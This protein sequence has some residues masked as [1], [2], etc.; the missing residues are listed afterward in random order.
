MLRSFLSI[1]LLAAALLA[2]GQAT[3]DAKILDYTGLRYSCEGSGTPVLK[4]QNAGSATM[5][6]CVVETWKNGLMVNSFNWI[7][8]VPALT[9][10]VRQPA[11]PVVPGL[12][13]GDQLEF[14]IIS[15]N[16]LPDEDPLGNILGINMDEV[17]SFSQGGS[18]EVRIELGDEPGAIVWSVT[19]ALNQVVA[20]GGPY[21]APNSEQV[22]ELNLPPGCYTFKAEDL[23]RS[24]G[25]DAVVAVARGGNTLVVASDLSTPYT[26]GLKAGAEAPCANSLTMEARTDEQG[27]ELAWEILSADG[28]TRYCTGMP[29]ADEAQ[30]IT[31]T[32]CVPDGCYR[33][34]VTDAG[35]DGIAGGGYVLREGSGTLRRIID[36]RSN[37][38]DGGT[39]AIAND[40]GFCLPMGSDRF[41]F[42]SC[43]KVDWRTAPCGAEYLVLNANAAV[44]AEYGIN[45]ANSGYQ[46]WWF[47]PNGGYS[48]KRFQSHSTSN[49]MPVGVTRAC[50]F[51]V[52]GWSGNQLQEGP[53]Y[54]VRARGRING[55][56]LEWGPACRFRID[57]VAAQCPATKL[58]DLPGNQYLSC[59]QER[60]ISNGAMVHARP[61]KRRNA[62]CN[63]VNANRYQFRFR[64]PLE[65]TEVVKTSANYWV[66]TMG[67][68][69]G[70]TY[71]V[72]V[73]ASFDNGATWC[74]AGEAWGV[75]CQLHTVACASVSELL[76]NPSESSEVR[77]VIYP[78]PA[79]GRAVR[80]V[81]DGF[82]SNEH[83]VD[84]E[85]LDMAGRRVF[86]R[87]FSMEPAD[88]STLRL[89]LPA[90]VPAGL[91]MVAVR[92][93][94]Q[95]KVERLLLRD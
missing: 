21:D 30:T 84:V 2:T 9:G 13:P 57:N 77:L 3:Y 60:P 59:G 64:L 52:N 19:N 90:N 31:N 87:V 50:H 81:L 69:C 34:V 35:G 56:Y 36:N 54:N 15:V 55:N 75:A 63:W 82:T 5:G 68:A 24:S 47:D 29:Y 92:V 85:V 45:N 16:G 70:K 73:R 39:S 41:T 46:V 10:D 38:S 23:T 86:A 72:D 65:G 51:M 25:P 40:E 71:E 37:F 8:A 53:L 49:G 20:T 18:M 14:H 83:A 61:V 28:A 48:F 17:P 93:G 6:T 12:E 42:I 67:L 89:E 66:N 80:V 43:D 76:V 11:L 33:L 1:A 94:S 88:P 62:A 78:N 7:L 44:S 74:Y 95:I 4:I 91:Y 22:D 79:E 58:M 32:C 26:K 27:S